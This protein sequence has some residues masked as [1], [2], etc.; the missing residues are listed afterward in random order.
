MFGSDDNYLKFYFPGALGAK[1][2][3]GLNDPDE[4]GHIRLKLGGGYNT[5]M[6]A[7]FGGGMDLT[8]DDEP[9]AVVLTAGLMI[10]PEAGDELLDRLNDEENTSY[11]QDDVSAAL[12]SVQPFVGISFFF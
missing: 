6:K 8:I 3:I 5:I 2:S 12:M 7:G 1:L 10:Y 4:K 11:T 9:T